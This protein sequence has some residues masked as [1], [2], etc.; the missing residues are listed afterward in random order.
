VGRLLREIGSSIAKSERHTLLILR[1]RVQSGETG[2]RILRPD[3][4]RS[5]HI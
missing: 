3:P 4:S 1:K 2:I 5:C